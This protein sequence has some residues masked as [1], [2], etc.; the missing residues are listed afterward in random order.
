MQP[1]EIISPDEDR[2]IIHGVY[3]WADCLVSGTHV[4]FAYINSG[5][6]P[7]DAWTLSIWFAM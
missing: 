2:S 5:C 7:Y 1:P 6:N 3:G 4:H